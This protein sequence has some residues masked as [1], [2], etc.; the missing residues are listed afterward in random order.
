MQY[1]QGFIIW[2]YKAGRKKGVSRTNFNKRYA[3]FIPDSLQNK[4]KSGDIVLARVETYSKEKQKNIKRAVPVLVS[5]VYESS[6]NE[7]RECILKI[8]EK[9]N[10]VTI[11][12]IEKLLD[13]AVKEEVVIKS[14]AW[15]KYDNK[16]LGQGKIKTVNYLME[17]NDLYQKIVQEVQNKRDNN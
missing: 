9:K 12:S 6:K 17:N 3:W 2:N 13:K 4:I 16:V 1:L 10:S 11:E 5:S 14:A 8:L 7:R 15:Y